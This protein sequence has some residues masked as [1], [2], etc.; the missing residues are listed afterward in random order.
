MERGGGRGREVE[1][2]L[3]CDIKVGEVKYR[4]ESGRRLLVRV[5][6]RAR[7]IVRGSDLR[8][9]EGRRSKKHK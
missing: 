5:T 4:R 7:R 8:G 9:G 6:W 3:H 2:L 1:N